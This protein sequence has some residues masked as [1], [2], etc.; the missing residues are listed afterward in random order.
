M[1]LADVEQ[2]LQQI[3]LDA[4]QD[5]IY[6]LLD[7]YGTPQASITKLRTGTYNKSDNED[8]VLWKRNLFDIYMPDA[9][10]DQLLVTLDRARTSTDI[11]KLKPRFYIAR[12]DEHLTAADNRTGQTLDISLA[13]LDRHAAF[14]MPWTG[15]EKTRTETSTYIDTKVAKQ[16]A[17]LYDEIIATNPDLPDT[18]QGRSDLNIFFSRLL[19]CFFAEDT[20]VFSEDGI[21]TDALSQLTASDGSDTAA[22]FDD[23]FEVL[24]TP[25]DDRKDVASHFDAFGYVNG[26]LF[27]DRIEAPTF[28]RKARNIVVDCGTLDWTAINPDIFGSMIQAVTAGE[29]RANLGMHYTSIENILKVLNPLFLDDLEERFDAADTVKKLEGLLDHLGEI[30]VFDPACGSGNFLIIAYKRLRSLEHRI[31]QRLGEIDSSK[32]AL[33]ADS[34]ISLEHFYGIEID[35]FAHDIAKLSL[36]FAKHQMNQEFDDLFGIERP[37]IPLT[38]TGAIH[39]ANATRTD[40][41]EICPAGDKTYICGNPPYLGSSLLEDT[42]KTDFAHYFDGQNYSKELDYIS[43]WFLKAADWLHGEAGAAFVSTNSI[44]QGQHVA[45]LWPPILDVGVE[46]NFA[47]TSFL[48]SN[49]ATGNAGVTCVVVGLSRT[50]SLRRKLMSTENVRQV[51]NINP[52]L[53]ESGDNTIVVKN[54]KALHGFTDITNG[55]KPAD[56]GHLSVEPHELSEF[57]AAAIEFIR[58]FVGAAELINAKSRFCLWIPDEFL[59]EA[60]RIDIVRDRLRRV[61]DFRLASKKESTRKRAAKPH[62]FDQIRYTESDC[63]AVPRHS[64]ERR[65]YI[66]MG[67]YPSGTVLSDAVSAL[68]NIEP[69]LF[70]LLHSSMHMAWVRTVG[71]RMKSDY[72]YSNTL[73]YNTYPFPNLEEADRSALTDSALAILAARERWPDRSLANLYD[74]DKMPANLRAAHEANDALVD[75]LYRKKPFESDADRMELLLALYRDLVA[76]ADK[77]EAGKSKKKGG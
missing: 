74:P 22:F 55:N 57:G 48:W 12:N 23:L 11:G 19:F 53:V 46:I 51:A 33:F 37:L 65:L 38:E 13:E 2:R 47:H 14:F 16:M 4:G 61:R 64:S 66:P 68:Y 49:N 1:K 29:D 67:F 26:S 18:E 42:H 30:R 7:A 58:P 40:W 5:L 21:F 60:E 59:L 44:C 6:E 27:S 62:Q 43:L 39:C 63:I 15:A 10:N 9:D 69:W 45:L 17:K 36:W 35:D 50:P 24:D 71:G 8:E 28:S 34:R 70:G 54:R 3:D 20:G 41:T 76:E 73:C 31:L 75:S 77:Q 25:E 32:A 72:R 52:Y 56:G